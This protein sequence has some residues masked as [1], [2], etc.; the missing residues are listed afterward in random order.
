MHPCF[1]V[2]RSMGRLC[3]PFSRLGGR[4][5]VR[6]IAASP[7]RSLP[8]SRIHYCRGDGKCTARLQ[9]PRKCM[10]IG[11]SRIGPFTQ[12]LPSRIP[13]AAKLKACLD[14]DQKWWPTPTASA[15]CAVMTLHGLKLTANSCQREV[16]ERIHLSRVAHPPRCL[17]SGKLHQ[18]QG[19]HFECQNKIKY[20]QKAIVVSFSTEVTC[21]WVA[22]FLRKTRI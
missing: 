1:S 12:L 13:D 18:G 6:C 16:L 17:L 4:S 15:D 7:Q 19:D 2:H 3:V 9:S 20:V 8:Y 14:E 22:E 5:V 10:P 11:P 21:C